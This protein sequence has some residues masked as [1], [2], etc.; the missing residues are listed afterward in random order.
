ME[1][2]TEEE[3]AVWN[4]LEFRTDPEK[5]ITAA[6]ISVRVG[7]RERGVREIIAGMVIRGAAPLP[8]IGSRKG[9]YVTRD[10]ALIRKFADELRH[11]CI[12]VFNH[13]R[14]HLETARRCGLIQDAADEQ[15]E[16]ALMAGGM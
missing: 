6:D 2:M 13:R 9:Y 5:P 15:M 4:V 10:P 14:G 1:K 8:I 12:E 11:H 3:Q 7:E 16:L